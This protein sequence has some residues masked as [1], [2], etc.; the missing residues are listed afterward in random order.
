MTLQSYIDAA[1]AE[2]QDVLK[3]G[4]KLHAQKKDAV[5]KALLST[6]RCKFSEAELKAMQLEVLENLAE[7][8][9]V[10]SFSGLATPRLAD[11]QAEDN[12]IPPMPKIVINRRDVGLKEE[13]A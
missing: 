3:D 2:L 7:L 11:Q 6:N 12:S 4:I 5:V 9:A 8:A 1:P 10:P 13:A